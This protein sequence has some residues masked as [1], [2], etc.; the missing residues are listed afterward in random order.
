MFR[1]TYNKV[2]RNLGAGFKNILGDIN[3]DTMYEHVQVTFM[4]YK[5]IAGIWVDKMKFMN[6]KNVDSKD[7]SKK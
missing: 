5:K 6:Y 7:R 4:R 1:E 3:D 2:L